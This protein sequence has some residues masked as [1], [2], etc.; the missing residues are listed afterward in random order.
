MYNDG[1]VRELKHAKG[2]GVAARGA[3]HVW[4]DL[5]PR[6]L[7][8]V[9]SDCSVDSFP[10]CVQQHASTLVHVC[11]TAC[12]HSMRPRLPFWPKPPRDTKAECPK[13]EWTRMISNHWMP[14]LELVITALD[15]WHHV[16]SLGYL[17]GVGWRKVQ[18]FLH[19]SLVITEKNGNNLLEPA[20]GG[21]ARL[22][23]AARVVRGPWHCARP[24]SETIAKTPKLKTCHKL[25]RLSASPRRQQRGAQ[26]QLL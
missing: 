3:I 16:V 18:L 5:R 26:P 23:G 20:G 12:V 2:L 17:E 15:N 21:R 1:E 10:K 22:R 9:E 11:S 4:N 19:C 14:S 8:R 24:R 6:V 25:A 7:A 13:G